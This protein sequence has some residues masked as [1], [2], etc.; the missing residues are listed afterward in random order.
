M[1]EAL[2]YV[3]GP[4]LS[5]RLGR[6]LGLDL[7]GARVCSMNCVYCESGALTTLTLG[8][9]AY[10]PADGILAE[11][12]AWE[13]DR[14]ARGEPAPDVVT[15]GGM[16]EPTL[17]SDLP[18]IIRGVRRI[19]PGVPV[20]VLTNASLMTDPQVREELAQA[21]MVLPSLDSLVAEEF[22][23]VNRGHPGLN[24]NDVA[25]GILA[26]RRETAGGKTRLYL[27]VL[28]V[29]GVNDSARNLELLEAFCNDLQPDRV[30]VT[31]L[32][33][34]GTEAW[35]KPVGKETLALWR[36]R[37]GTAGREA[38]MAGAEDSGPALAQRP[39]KR[40]VRAG[41]TA[42]AEVRARI[43]TAILASVA[44]RPQTAGQLAGALLA[45]RRDVERALAE[46]VAQGLAEEIRRGGPDDPAEA[47]DP[48]GADA[49][50]QARG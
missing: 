37:L 2:Q 15:L 48:A 17:N 18:E 23:R 20:A 21:D 8:R 10:V 42:P 49:Y 41:G 6:S 40:Q 1:S 13:R 50:Y 24:P 11:L 38:E 27:E 35:A 47:D 33:R 36:Q 22:A 32:S 7:L 44:R 3:F 31:T 26:F 43:Q 14:A 19:L 45:D 25:D 12:A 16:G 28:L 39:E 34:P 4:V 5:G 29:L 46:L 9:K 30:D